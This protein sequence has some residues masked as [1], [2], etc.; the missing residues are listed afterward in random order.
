MP[1]PKR[2]LKDD[3]QSIMSDGKLP[4]KSV[5]GLMGEGEKFFRDQLYE[6][7]ILC[8]TEALELSPGNRNAL[9]ER[10]ACYLRIGKNDLA[11]KDAE[12]SLKENKDSTKSL[13]QKAEALYAM[14]EFE[15]AL[16]FYHRG[17]RL[18]SDI[19][20]FHL[21]ISKAEEAINNCVGD[22]NL[23]KLEIK[24][25][26]SFFDKPDEKSKKKMNTGYQKPLSIKPLNVQNR[27]KRIVKTEN[28]KAVKQLL[29]ELY[30]DKV[31]LENL[32]GDN[33]VTRANTKSGDAIYGLANNGLNYLDSR[34]D[35]WRQQKPIYARKNNLSKTSTKTPLDYILN[36]LEIIDN[37]QSNGKYSESLEKS[38]KLMH[39][40]N[41]LSDTQ[42]P[43]KKSII[44]NLYS[45]IGNAHL[46]MGKYILALDNHQKDLAISKETGNKEGIS[47]AYENIGRVYARSGQ[48]KKAI[49]AWENKLP[50]AESDMEKAWLFHEIGR[51]HLELGNY[52]MAEDFGKKSLEHSN[53]IPDDVWILNAT[54][55]MAQSQAKI[56][57]EENLKIAI[58]NFEKALIMTEKLKDEAGNKAI[59]KA[60]EAAKEKLRKL[61]SREKDKFDNS[62]SDEKNK[63]KNSDNRKKDKKSNENKQKEQNNDSPRKKN[64]N[65]SIKKDLNKKDAVKTD[66]KFQ[67]KTAS[68]ISSG[69]DA[70]VYISLFGNEGELLD[71]QMKSKSKDK[72]TFE[73]GKIDTFD[74]SGLNSV[75]KLKKIS[76]G[77][78]S[79]NSAWKLDYVNII[80]NNTLYKFIANKWLDGDLKKSNEKLTSIELEPTSIIENI[81]VYEIEVKT[82]DE[83]SAGTDAN[84]YLDIFGTDGD[85]IKLEL[86]EP[87]DNENPFERNALNKFVVIEKNIGKIKKI[88]VFT[89]A[90]GSGSSWKL[91]YVKILLN[92]TYYNFSANRWIDS[93]TELIQDG[94]AIQ[95]S[96]LVEYTISVLTADKMGAGTD[97]N[98]FINIHG[99]K[100]ETGKIQ[101]ESSSTNKNPFE[102]GKLDIFQSKS[103]NVGEINKIN[104]S[105]DGKGTGAGWFCEKVVI[106]HGEITKTFK[107]GRWLDES[108]EDGK[109][110]IDVQPEVASEKNVSENN[111]KSES[112]NLQQKQNESP[113]KKNDNASIQ[114]D[115]NKK[116]AVKTD[117][118]FQIK[119]A[120]D[121]SSG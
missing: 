79:P 67:I 71:L 95:V 64:D 32:L 94:D 76:I 52:K 28:K 58:E 37:L 23:V 70:N 43:D 112:K 33:H 115:L 77:H 85:I 103:R 40:V 50:Y 41:K 11:L 1:L 69:I 14:G 35:F 105:H 106:K 21:G 54:I 26:L 27:E 104:I 19:R 99:T 3:E 5:P 30:A 63:N 61:Q 98:V 13:Y 57:D 25:D 47:R 121:I 119:T 34:T 66:H 12:E 72:N 92:K 56:G 2:K 55:L 8:Y 20:E 110:S 39:Y 93:K 90:K 118:K 45:F 4:I 113:R 36:Q 116:D 22:P 101:L 62:D 18:R 111:S 91:S 15:L 44:S 88:A 117:Y 68:D 78:D 29:G 114:K 100:G 9:V 107:I 97:A 86:K 96:D 51:C 120:S 53:N 16:V 84:V 24:G 17:K 108:E 87:L 109:I 38:N 60:L 89:E 6:K 83:I 42:V 65:A 82:A 102:K 73:R 81:T 75:G 48:F 80:F 59:K 46:E 74:L 31:Y 7:A 10:A 49:E